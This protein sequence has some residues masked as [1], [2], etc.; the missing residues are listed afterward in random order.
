MNEDEDVACSGSKVT[1]HKPRRFR[2]RAL[3]R[4]TK[5]YSSDLSE[6]EWQIMRP[7]L[8][9]RAVNGRGRKRQVNEQEIL[10]AIFY[11]IHNGCMWSDLL[12]DIPAWQTVYQYFRRWQRKGVWQL[13]RDSLR[14]Q[15][16]ASSVGKAPHAS[17]RS[18]DSQSVKTTEKRGRCT[19][20][21]AAN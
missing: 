20:S 12:K 19:A 9:R 15:V 1:T 21:T 6:Q 11:Q 14:P 18:I 5:S 13:L 17:A 16:R 10:N 2:R 7:L 8:P 4:A 3:E